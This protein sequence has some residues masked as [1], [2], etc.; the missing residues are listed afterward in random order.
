MGIMIDFQSDDFEVRKIL[1]SDNKWYELH[2]SSYFTKDTFEIGAYD[3]DYDKYVM[4]TDMGLGFSCVLK[5]G[6]VLK[7]KL[8]E[9]K[10]FITK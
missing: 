5:N 10:A 7:G 4:L 6:D 3:S 1:L 9:V 8:S 2:K